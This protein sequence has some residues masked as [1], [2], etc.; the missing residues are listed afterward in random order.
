MSS[1]PTEDSLMT[2]K[3]ISDLHVINECKTLS[4][5]SNLSLVGNCVFRVVQSNTASSNGIKSSL[6]VQ[7]QHNI[8]E[9]NTSSSELNV[10][11]VDQLHA[12]SEVEEAYA[13]R[14]HNSATGGKNIN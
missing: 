3:N 9:C 7:N 6:E 4:P 5:S 10:S 13:K 14:Q 8:N 11:H 1:T 2:Q 12:G